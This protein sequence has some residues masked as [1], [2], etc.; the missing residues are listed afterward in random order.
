MRQLTRVH[1]R[2]LHILFY[3]ILN[4]VDIS[5]NGISESDD[6]ILNVNLQLDER[7]RR[8][9]AMDGAHLYMHKW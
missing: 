6:R 1:K 2:F 3:F 5:H 7:E 8:R 4:K 9:A